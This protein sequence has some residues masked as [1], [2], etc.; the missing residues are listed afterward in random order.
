MMEA[1]QNTTPHKH[2]KNIKKAKN[3][4]QRSSLCLFLGSRNPHAKK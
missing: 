4:A 2:S 1:E 3:V